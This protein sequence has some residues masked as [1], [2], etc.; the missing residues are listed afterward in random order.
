M[1]NKGYKVTPEFRTN[2]LHEKGD[3]HQVFVVY[4]DKPTKIYDHV[5]YPLKYIDRIKESTD[6]SNG[7]IV[8]VYYKEMG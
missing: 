6:Y 2:P 3:G 4:K 1:K 5:Q 7:S 8:D